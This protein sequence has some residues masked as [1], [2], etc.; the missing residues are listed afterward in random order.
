MRP[1]GE[2]LAAAGFPVRAVRLPG[3]GT[4]VADLARSGWVD[5]LEAASA[6]LALLA[7]DVPR[8]AIAGQSMGALLAIRLAVTR[9]RE[10]AALVLCATALDVRGLRARLLPL[11]RRVPPL[12]R[13]WALLPKG[14]RDI[15]DPVARAESF[16]YD[17]MP[18]AAVLQLLALQRI[19]RRELGRVTQ[20]ALLLHGR[21]DH[22]IPVG[23]LG[24]LRRG[25]GSG[26]IEAHVLERS[27]H[28][29]T[30]DRDRDEVG[31]LA[32]DFLARV[33]AADASRAGSGRA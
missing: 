12:A 3:H 23:Q 24:R 7:R 14:A 2:A 16:T 33:A 18:L 5:W 11:V 29:V 28:V 8:V 17:A 15:A 30:L 1:L 26:W 6:A 25:L 31:R 22:T 20:P 9:P 10:I 4:N 32:A 19:V 27:W 13:R 21:D